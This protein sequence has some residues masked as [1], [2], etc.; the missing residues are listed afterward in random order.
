MSVDA[1]RIT[2]HRPCDGP[3]VYGYLRLTSRSVTRRTALLA[4][5]QGYCEQHELTLITTF[6]EYGTATTDLPA[7]FAG[8][9]DVLTLA[10]TYGVVMPSAPHL[11][12]GEIAVQR[13]RH[14]AR[15]GGRLLLIRP[16]RT[17][18]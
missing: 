9:L 11:G 5:L 17:Q 2:E 10:D 14:I 16:N 6:T 18:P 1:V 13:R 4:A 12:R 3:V 7:A 8:L 15:A